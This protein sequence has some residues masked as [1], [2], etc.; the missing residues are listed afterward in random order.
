MKES[1]NVMNGKPEILNCDNGSEFINND[2]KKFVKDNNI[3]VRYV[4]VGD[5]HKLGI[6]DRFNRTLRDKINKLLTIK[7][8]TR[9]IDS[10]VSIVNNYNDTFHSG[11]NKVPRD[12]K[13]EDASI[14]VLN[15]KKY[16]KALK[17][18]SKFNVGD[19]VR[20]IKN[21]VTFQKGSLP[22]WSEI[23]EVI[24]NTKHT[25]TLDNNKT[26][27]YYELIKLDHV[28]VPV[29]Q[30]AI[31]PT[32]EKIRKD[33]K[34]KRILRREEMLPENIIEGKRQVKRATTLKDYI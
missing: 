14:R 8:T 28:E 30:S 21:K 20:Y 1:F 18:E 6:V 7:N 15:N 26:Y 11:I 5:H 13:D 24:D 9:Y 25:Y 3:E 22:K 29:L 19:K 2:F 4:Q 16:V 32:R 10:F 31:T 27:K 34:V 17:E 23:H 12:V 33:N